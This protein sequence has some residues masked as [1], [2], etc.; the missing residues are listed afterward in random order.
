MP[1]L[2]PQPEMLFFDG[3]CGLCHY[4]VKF[5]VKQDRSGMAFRFAP[6]YGETFQASIPVPQRMGLPDSMVVQTSDGSLLMRSDAWVHVLRRLGGKWKLV[7][8]LLHII[9][10]PVRNFFYRLVARTR[11]HV[12]GSREE[13]CPMMPPNLR[14]RFHP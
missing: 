2:A 6:L 10:R 14:T 1:A 11:Y 5:L 3:H 12:F 9:P 13:I 8:V 4:A 7:A